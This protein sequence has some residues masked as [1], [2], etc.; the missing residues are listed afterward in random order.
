MLLDMKFFGDEEGSFWENLRLM[1]ERSLERKKFP[2][3]SSLEGQFATFL[4]EPLSTVFGKKLRGVKKLLEG[5][6]FSG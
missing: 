2:G 3:I 4:R 1:P 5:A 6:K